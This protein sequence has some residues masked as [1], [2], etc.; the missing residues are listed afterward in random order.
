[1]KTVS[2]VVVILIASASA[3]FAQGWWPLHHR[4][5]LISRMEFELK[6]PRLR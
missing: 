4:Q 2:L 5:L 3:A 1:M 6:M